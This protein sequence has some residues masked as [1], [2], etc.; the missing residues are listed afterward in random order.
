MEHPQPHQL[1][2]LHA[3][4]PTTDQLAMQQQ[5][6]TH[7][8]SQE[9]QYH[10]YLAEPPFNNDSASTSGVGAGTAGGSAL[11]TQPSPYRA[12]MGSLHHQLAFQYHQPRQDDMTPISHLP[13]HYQVTSPADTLQHNRSASVQ[14]EQHIHLDPALSQYSHPPTE[15]LQKVLT[16]QNG[17]SYA[18]VKEQQFSKASIDPADYAISEA[19]LGEASGSTQGPTRPRSFTIPRANPPA[20]SDV[21]AVAPSTLVPSAPSSHFDFTTHIPSTA[22]ATTYQA[23]QFQV[24]PQAKATVALSQPLPSPMNAPRT[25]D[26]NPSANAARQQSMSSAPSRAQRSD[27]SASLQMQPHP[28]AQQL[29]PFDNS[30]SPNHTFRNLR[31]ADWDETGS[32]MR[33]PHARFQSASNV[34]GAPTEAV[35]GTPAKLMWDQHGRMA[36]LES[37]TSSQWVSRQM[38]FLAFPCVRCSTP[39]LTTTTCLIF[40]ESSRKGHVPPGRSSSDELRFHLDVGSRH[41]L[42]CESNLLAS[43]A[44][45][46]TWSIWTAHVLFLLYRF[47]S[48]RISATAA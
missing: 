4:E 14:Q 1:Q 36:T 27:S 22:N 41:S 43:A 10:A 45:A 40:V 28:L 34:R 48:C 6:S 32:P 38:G 29:F 44:T 13:L 15:P 42:A 47:W 21:I 18:L 8:A 9:P 7:S 3:T 39:S 5:I 35:D 30:S 26:L 16:W 31:A 37:I 23:L 17:V 12:A 11:Q 24:P 33:I 25:I 19:P 2:H 46:C 20:V